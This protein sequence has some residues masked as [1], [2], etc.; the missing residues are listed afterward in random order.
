MRVEKDDTMG[1]SKLF[2]EL[3]Y[4]FNNMFIEY[5]NYIIALPSHTEMMTC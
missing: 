5:E 4:I 2:E 1:R 3:S